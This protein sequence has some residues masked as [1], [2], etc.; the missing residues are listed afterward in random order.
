MDFPEWYQ[1]TAGPGISK[2]ILGV[3]LN[4][5]PVF[6]LI[7]AQFGWG[8]LGEG[9]LNAVVSAGVFL[10]FSVM[11]VWGYV[12]SKKLLGAKIQQLGGTL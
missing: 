11:S 10:V 7:T 9:T 3:V 2:T 6:N 8:V 5:L 4:L 12:R 1:S